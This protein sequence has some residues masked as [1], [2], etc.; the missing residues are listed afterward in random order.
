[1]KQKKVF[2]A[3]VPIQVTV[4]APELIDTNS[5]II[6]FPEN[7]SSVRS[8]DLTPWL[9][10][11]IDA[12][13]WAG[14]GQLRALLASKAVTL[15]TIISYWRG[16]L[17]F[18]FEYIIES[19]GAVDPWDLKPLHILS[20]IGWIKDHKNWAYRTQK[21]KYTHT[22]SILTAM[23]RR[24]VVPNHENLFPS[25]PFPN[26]N[27]ESKG[28]KPL[29]QKERQGLV[30]ALV[31]DIIAIHKGAF[32]GTNSEAM[33]VYLLS[34]AIR[35]GANTA[36]LLEA[37]RKCL[38][39]HPFMPNM[40]VIELFKRRGNGTKVSQLRY[41]DSYVSNVSVPMDGVAL[42]HKALQTSEALVAKA[43]SEYQDRVWLYK[44]SQGSTGSKIASLTGATLANGIAALIKRQSLRGDDGQPLLLNLSRLRKTLEMRLWSLSGGDLIATAALMGH[45]PKTAEIHYL[46]CTQKM[47]E[48]AT[49]V[50][51]ALPLMYRSGDAMKTVIP[52]LP[53][54]SPTG[55]CKDPYDGDKA[56]KNGEPCDDFFSCFSCKSYAIVGSPEDLH[57]LFSFY[58]FLER[59]MNHARTQDWRSEFRH[60][61]NL[62]DRF[63]ED[64]FDIDLIVKAKE[65]AK[66][67]PLKFW[68]SFTL[69]GLGEV[70]G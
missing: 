47:R 37:S 66:I 7:P 60:T 23:G 6:A 46:A 21:S 14:A 26:S 34:I 5:L 49:F 13:V 15:V 58:W 59:E 43:K 55:R 29:S 45:G 9:D 51:E 40:K 32:M 48:N 54:K 28:A 25:N 50:G 22:K 68:A 20:Y 31:A 16:G 56:P 3:P 61:M 19:G 4:E 2:S 35:T 36:P 65:S 18:F 42:L 64:K 44:S 33:V 24:A 30:K 70:N 69:R 27:K 53:G 39:D 12:W 38:H 57:R 41:S 8:I 67:N 63:T 52:N 17:Q 11:G 10:R 62:I 1:M